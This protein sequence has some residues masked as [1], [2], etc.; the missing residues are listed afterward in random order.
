MCLASV[1]FVVL[2]YGFHEISQQHYEKSIVSTQAAYIGVLAELYPEAEPQLVEQI[3]QTRPGAAEKG[4]RIMEKYGV[5]LDELSFNSGAVQDAGQWNILLLFILNLSICTVFIMLAMRFARQQYARVRHVTAYTKDI[6]GGNYHLDI[7]D[8]AEG[9]LS[10]LKNEIYKITT[11]LRE[12]TEK[13]KQDKISLADSL[14]DISHQLKTPMTSLFV[15]TDLLQ[16]YPDKHVHDDF[17]QRMRSK[18][19][20]MEWLVSSLLKL[21]KLEAGTVRMKQESFPLKRLIDKTLES[22]AIPMDIKMQ[23]LTMDGEQNI[24]VYG[25]LNWLNEALLNLLKNAIEHTPEHGHIQ[26]KWSDNPLFTQILVTD[27]GEGI[28]REE[29]P[30]VFQRFFKGKNAG[31]DSVGIGLA[32]AHAIVEAHGG[33]ITVKS[34]PGKG[35]TFTITLQK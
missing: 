13:W 20:R 30:Y 21:S 2:A 34:E 29:Q 28:D 5:N 6:A 26:M 23:T 10:I 9:E 32:M 18:L 25:D 11:M 7:R 35:S 17:L 31:D 12:Q 33:D 1:F 27:D 8:N 24:T 19:N 14:A 3:Y 4:M 16:E 22:M 15:L